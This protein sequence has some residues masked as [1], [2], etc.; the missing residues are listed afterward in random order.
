MTAK[1]TPGPWVVGPHKRGL[2]IRSTATKGVIAVVPDRPK[3]P[4]EQ[5]ALDAHIMAA[6]PR[7]L[8]SLEALEGLM[9]WEPEIACELGHIA[10]IEPLLSAAR[11]AIAKVRGGAQ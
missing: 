8:E 11:A 7:L 5:V 4:E 2:V 9:E 1:P 10:E 6:A 3:L